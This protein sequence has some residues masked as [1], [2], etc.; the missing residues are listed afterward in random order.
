MLAFRN[1]ML[2]SRVVASTCLVPGGID[3]NLPLLLFS[4]ILFQFWGEFDI[5]YSEFWIVSGGF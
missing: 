4:V 2:F 5:E 3:E 1:T